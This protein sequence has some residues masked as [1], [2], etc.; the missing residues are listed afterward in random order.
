[1]RCLRVQLHR[2]RLRILRQLVRQEFQG[3]KTAKLRVLGLI[4]NAHATTT[5]SFKDVVVRKGLAD[6]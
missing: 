4:D 1:M 6:A 5:D 2:K 3:N